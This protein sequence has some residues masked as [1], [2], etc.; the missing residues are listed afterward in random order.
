TRVASG[1]V[2]VTV[3][4]LVEKKQLHG[5]VSKLDVAEVRAGARFG[6]MAAV[7][8]PLLPE[9]PFGPLGGIRPRLLWALVL[10]FS[11][12]SFVGYVARRA[13]GSD[14]GYALAGTLGG[15]VSST[16]VT[17]TFARLSRTQPAAAQP[18]ASGTLGANLVLFPR[19][20]L[21]TAVLAPALTVA[22][23]PAFVAPAAIGLALLLRGLRHPAKAGPP[24]EDRNPLQFVAALQMVLLFQAVLFGVALA[25]DVFGHAGIYGSAAVLG[26]VDMDALTI[27]MARL[28]VAGTAAEAA[29]RAVTIGVLAN[30]CVKLGI[31][32]VVGRG[33]FRPLA[34]AGL[35][36]M[37]AAL[38]AALYWTWPQA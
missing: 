17:L 25:R 20:L 2:A 21:A 28:V 7:V 15:L 38:A 26:L 22:L 9:G 13:V 12:L 16:S 4:L 27:S 30:T 11:G 5:L 18:L 29:A 6:V 3:L 32:L 35:A 1:I 36:G 24:D 8:L 10:F 34:A 19:V 37:A 33:R 14:K 31:T 23:W